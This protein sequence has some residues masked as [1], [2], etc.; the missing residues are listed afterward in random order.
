M[1]VLVLL[2]DYLA[3]PHKL[4]DDLFQRLNGVEFYLVT[5]TS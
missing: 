4:M 5:K 1:S 2:H 3:L